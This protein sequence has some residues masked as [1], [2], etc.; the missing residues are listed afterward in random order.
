MRKVTK[1]SIPEVI[2]RLQYLPNRTP[3]MA[4]TGG[5]EKAFAELRKY[6]DGAVYAGFYSGHSEWERHSNGDEI[7]L[8]LEGST[9]L[10]LRQ[11]GRDESI[12]LGASELLVVPANTWHRFEASKNLKILT[13]T[14]Q[15]TDH[16][17]DLTD[18]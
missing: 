16:S 14:P 2:A 17:L 12:R 8:V 18:A 3:A 15:P 10:V 13:V 6:R 5:A 1:T 9:T 4:F 7:V 11:T